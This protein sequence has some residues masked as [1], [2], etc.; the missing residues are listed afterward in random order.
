MRHVGGLAELEGRLDLV[1]L[2]PH[3]RGRRPR[4]KV[5]RAFDD[6]AVE[7]HDSVC[8]KGLSGIKERSSEQVEPFG[9]IGAPAHRPMMMMWEHILQ[10]KN[11]SSKILL[12]LLLLLH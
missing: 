1:Q 6:G 5:G 11:S 4:V 12:L 10:R 3:V 2:V 7:R 9:D 8:H